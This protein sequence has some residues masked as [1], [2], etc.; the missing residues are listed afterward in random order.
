MIGIRSAPLPVLP[1]KLVDSASIADA[2]ASR[3]SKL[4]APKGKAHLCLV[5]QGLPSTPTHHPQLDQ[6][7]TL[8]S[9]S[10]PPDYMGH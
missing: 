6:L 3:C 1:S 9:Y 10:H 8:G 4:G 2:N 5:R 7:Q